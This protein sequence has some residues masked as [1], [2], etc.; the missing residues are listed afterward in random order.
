MALKTGQLWHSGRLW[1][2][3][4]AVLA[5]GLPK[6]TA[7]SSTTAADP[8]KVAASD[9]PAPPQATANANESTAI[10]SRGSGLLI[11]GHCRQARSLQGSLA[12]CSAPRTGPRLR[13]EVK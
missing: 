7:H 8:S 3:V 6:S 10:D 1:A 13:M 11:N 4:S 5:L 2:P 12:A 9:A